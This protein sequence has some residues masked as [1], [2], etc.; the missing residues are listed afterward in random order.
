MIYISVV[1]IREKREILFF[2]KRNENK[3]L[4]VL[5][6]YRASGIFKCIAIVI[7]TLLTI[8]SVEHNFHTKIKNNVKKTQVVVHFRVTGVFKKIVNFIKFSK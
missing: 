2:I 1:I 5:H 6:Q 3:V 8:N 4:T 7:L